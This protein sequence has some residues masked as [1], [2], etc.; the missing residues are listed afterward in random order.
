MDCDLTTLIGCVEIVNGVQHSTRGGR[1][2][3]VAEPVLQAQHGGQI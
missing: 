3:A 2:G 1:G